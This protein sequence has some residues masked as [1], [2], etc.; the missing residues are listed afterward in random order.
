MR[1]SPQESLIPLNT[2]KLL[3]FSDTRK[4]CAYFL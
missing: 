3:T 2:A 1:N 4:Y